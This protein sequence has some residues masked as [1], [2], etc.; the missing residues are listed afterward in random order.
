M[1]ILNIVPVDRE[2]LAVGAQISGDGGA[3]KWETKESAVEIPIEEIFLLA[4]TSM[5]SFD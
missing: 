1:E 4:L 5:S 3:V 2:Q